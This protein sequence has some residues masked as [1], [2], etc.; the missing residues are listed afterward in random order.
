M[1][2]HM[3]PL[4]AQVHICMCACGGQR[5]VSGVTIYQAQG[6]T[7][8]HPHQSGI[9]SQCYYFY[10]F[11]CGVCGSKCRSRVLML[12]GQTLH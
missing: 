10:C 4:F 11:L 1:C 5:T 12:A 8:P 2:V 3:L 6:L 7:C 9:K